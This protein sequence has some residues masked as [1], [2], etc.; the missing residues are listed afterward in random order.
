MSTCSITSPIG[1]S[2][3]LPR[4]HSGPHITRGVH[5]I[6]E[7]FTLKPYISIYNLCDKYTITL[8]FNKHDM[9]IL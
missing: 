5:L 3:T 6:Y 1:F 2:C 9:T 7:I 4:G 8:K